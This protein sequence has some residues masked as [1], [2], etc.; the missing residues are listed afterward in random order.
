MS[1]SKNPAARLRPGNLTFLIGNLSTVL[2]ETASRRP[3]S[4]RRKMRGVVSGGV[5]GGV[6]GA[7]PPRRIASSRV[8]SVAE[9]V[10]SAFRLALHTSN[11]VDSII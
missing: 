11:V 4:A 9:T 6:S 7:P 2:S 3:T 10:G 8:R 1:D 5:A